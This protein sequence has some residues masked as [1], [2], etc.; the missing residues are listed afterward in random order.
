MASDKDES[1]A[2]LVDSAEEEGM[3][4]YLSQPGV[5]SSRMER[6]QQLI[7]AKTL[8]LRNEIV[9]LTKKVG[10]LKEELKQM[11]ETMNLSIERVEGENKRLRHQF[12]NRIGSPTQSEVSEREKSLEIGSVH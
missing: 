6:T 12:E 5:K 3:D 10:R 2:I 7:E 9:E 1:D 4:K 11:S 8:P